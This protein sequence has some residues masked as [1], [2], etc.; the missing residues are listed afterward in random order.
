[1]N[2]KIAWLA[3]YPKT[4]STWVR[5][6]IQQLLAPDI[7]GKEAIPSFHRDYPEDAPTYAILG[8]DAKLLRTHCYPGHPIFRALVEQ[9]SDETV[10][11][12]T[13]Q[14]HPLDVLLSQLNYSFIRERK[15]S[16][17]DGILKKVEDV[18]A[19]GE[20]DYYIDEFVKVGGCPEYVGRC[21]SYRN[22]YHEWRN[23]ASDVPH[24][25]L[26]YEDMVRD[27]IGGIDALGTFFGVRDVNA[28]EVVKQVEKR[29]QVNGKFFWRKK[30]YNHRGLLPKKS[31]QRFEEAYSETLRDLGYHEEE[32]SPCL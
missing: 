19:D 11:V 8:T 21:Q 25:N 13:I 14:R 29:T 6:I 17:K 9:R 16:F 12:I 2:D 3:A 10:G 32:E 28:S 31:I 22:F 20:I 15:K 23:L 24:L 5:T 30:A 7:R 1:M 26:R 27:P 18:V 4:G